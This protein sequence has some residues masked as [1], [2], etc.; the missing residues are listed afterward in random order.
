LFLTSGRFLGEIDPTFTLTGLVGLVLTLLAV[1]GN[2]GKFERK[3]W[4]FEIDAGLLILGYI[5]G[6]YFLYTRGI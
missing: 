4:I 1:V 3:I 6:L 5:A 2:V